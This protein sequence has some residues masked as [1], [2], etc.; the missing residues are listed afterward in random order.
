MTSMAIMKA[1]SVVLLNNWALNKGFLIILK[2]IHL[3]SL[4]SIEI[5]DSSSLYSSNMTINVMK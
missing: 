5:S 4:A 2:M 3:I 1:N